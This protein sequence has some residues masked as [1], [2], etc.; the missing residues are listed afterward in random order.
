LSYLNARYYNSAQGQ[1]L[2]EDPVFLGNPNQQSLQDPQSLNTYSY[3]DDNPINKSDPNGKWYVDLG[4]MG[5]ANGV[6]ASA[7]IRFNLTNVDW[8]FGV[9]GGFGAYGTAGIS[10]NPFDNLPSQRKSELEAGADY[11]EGIA[12]G[13]SGS[14]NL[15]PYTNVLSDYS[16]S[17]EA[18]ISKGTGGV[19]AGVDIY[20]RLSTINPISGDRFN[21][22]K[23][24]NFST[25]NYVSSIRTSTSNLISNEA[26]PQT[27]E[28]Y[29][30]T[31]AWID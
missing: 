27:D 8:Y 17:P 24:S 22:G 6:S 7:G 21:I 14:A 18:A 28:M 12:G 26:T 29:R 31:G 16:I 19:G 2:S 25:P 13:V 1:F 30:S 4:V 5:T 9:G 15:N 10:I 3:S 20:G 23:Q 11:G